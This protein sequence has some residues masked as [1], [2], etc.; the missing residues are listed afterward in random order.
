MVT[1]L[2]ILLRIHVLLL[3]IQKDILNPILDFTIFS[4]QLEN[5]IRVFFLIGYTNDLFSEMLNVQ[6][7]LSV[8]TIHNHFAST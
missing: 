8:T 6:D 1:V 2:S 3:L 4:I 7:Y 5:S